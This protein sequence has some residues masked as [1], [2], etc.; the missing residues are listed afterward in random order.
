MRVAIPGILR[1]FVVYS[2]PAPAIARKPAAALVFAAVALSLVARAQTAGAYKVTNLISDG[3]VPANV[4]DPNFI[5]PW[6]VSDSGTWWI[7]AQGTGLNYVVASTPNLGTINFKVIIPPASGTGTGLPSG[8]VTTAGAVGM[9]LP[10]ATKASFLFST[11]DGTISGWNSKLGTANAVCQIV[12]NNSAAGAVYTGMAIVNTGTASYIL[13]ANFGAGKKIETYDSTFQP[14][15]L[16]GSFTDPTLPAGYAPFSVHV[17]NGKV[18]VAY[19]LRSTTTPY[20]AVDGAGNGAVSVFDTSGNFIARIATGGNLNSPWGVAIAP[21]NFGIFGGSILIGNFG[22]GVINAYDPSGFSYRGQLTDSAA[23]PLTYATLWELLP[24]G[25]TVSNTTSV[26]GGDPN[27]V[28]F[29][30]GLNLEAHGLFGAI[31]N[32]TSSGTATFALTTATN[33]ITVASGAT[34]QTRVSL[35]PIYGFTGTVNLSCTGLPAGASCSF[36]PAQL[37]SNGT[38]PSLYDV[39]ILTTKNTA[40]FETPKGHLND[41]AYALLLPFASLM[42]FRR[43]LSL[44]SF[45]FFRVILLCGIVLTGLGAISGCSSG[46]TTPPGTSQ[47]GIT[48]TAGSTTRTATVMLIVQ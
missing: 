18:Y 13:V 35:Q 40:L 39:S 37:S 31:S 14:A 29:T 44:A 7:S 22:D 48:A 1:R 9:I 36:A 32:D 17:L 42:V 28:Y 27:T 34:A 26:S 24:G 2:T 19:A 30:A 3:S 11:L 38:T 25:T 15:Q 43:R 10:N 4:T 45:G 23:K 20:H 6:A 33:S 47:V 46:A 16:A 41:I 21:A 12:I 5:N 8:S